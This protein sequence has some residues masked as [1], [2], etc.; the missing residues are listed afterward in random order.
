MVG[1]AG[2]AQAVGIVSIVATKFASLVVG[3]DALLDGSGDLTSCADGVTETKSVEMIGPHETSD[4]DAGGDG[5]TETKTVEMIGPDKSSDMD[6]GAET[7]AAGTIEPDAPPGS[8]VVS[9]SFDAG[10]M[11]T[12]VLVEEAFA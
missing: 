6:A 11:P 8:I 2:Q 4:L 7:M 5:V 12:A 3:V 1:F 9:F 10:T